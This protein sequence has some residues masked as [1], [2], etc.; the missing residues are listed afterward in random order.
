MFSA[1]LL[2]NPGTDIQK[3]NKEL[4]AND[5]EGVNLYQLLPLKDNYFDDSVNRFTDSFQQGN[6]GNIMILSGVAFLILLVGIF[7][8]INIYTVLM[9]KRARELGMK[10]SLERKRHKCWYNCLAKI[11][12]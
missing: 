10:R 4:V 3:L 1:C 9:L 6:F 5:R 2:L 11:W 8:F 7:N 12:P